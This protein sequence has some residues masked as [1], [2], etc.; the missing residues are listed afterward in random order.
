MHQFQYLQIQI[1]HEQKYDT[2]M[3]LLDDGAMNSRE[4]G[5]LGDFVDARE[6]GGELDFFSDAASSS[7]QLGRAVG[8]AANLQANMRK[9]QAIFD[10]NV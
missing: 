7:S 8:R 4:A 3:H 10:D 6:A 9:R 1:A 2:A 5:Q